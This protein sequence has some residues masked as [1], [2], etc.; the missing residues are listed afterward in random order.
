MRKTNPV[1]NIVTAARIIAASAILFA[2]P[3]SS[4]FFALYIFCGL[5]DILDGFLA[6]RLHAESANGALLDSAADLIFTAVI[7]IKL[8]PLLGFQTWQ[9]VW[10]GGIALVK[11][12]ALLIGT[13]RFRKTAFIH[14]LANKGTGLLLFFFPALYMLLGLDLTAVILCA[15]AT[16]AAIEELLINIT[17]KAFDR[18]RKSIFMK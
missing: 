10:I 17:A 11:L 14:T 5:S 3:L 2:E 12:T 16:V 7:L 9:L 8:M 13:L 1:P 6:R 18:D 15:A 4:A